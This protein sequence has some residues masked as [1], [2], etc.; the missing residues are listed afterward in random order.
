M[1]SSRMGG[2]SASSFAVI[3]VLSRDMLNCSAPLRTIGQHNAG[4]RTV[5]FRHARSLSRTTATG[6]FEER[7]QE[8]PPLQSITFWNCSR[9]RTGLSVSRSSRISWR[10][11]ESKRRKS[12]RRWTRWPRKERSPSKCA[13]AYRDVDE[14]VRRGC[15][16][17]I[18]VWQDAHL[19]ADPVQSRRPNQRGTYC[20]VTDAHLYGICPQ[21]TD[22][23][24][25]Q[26][27][28]SKALVKKEE[29]E[30]HQLKKGTSLLT[31]SLC[32]G[33]NLLEYAALKSMRTLEEI[34]SE[35]QRLETQV[36]RRASLCTREGTNQ[37]FLQKEESTEKLSTLKEKSV[38]VQPEERATTEKVHSPVCLPVCLHSSPHTET[39]RPSAAVEELEICLLRNLVCQ[40]L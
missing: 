1:L 4:A 33:Y 17:T 38:V 30:L 6:S 14:T 39:A 26:V 15:L 2:P 35:I 9:T 27:N 5:H 34:E 10:S 29:E 16:P 40:P 37:R 8:R 23:K 7:C 12:R 31:A 13:L 32:R 25:Q 19:L 18:G 22:A 3:S 21:E 28:E 11:S 36:R 24:K 20:A